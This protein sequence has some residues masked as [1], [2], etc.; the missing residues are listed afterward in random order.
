VG[1]DG[2]ALSVSLRRLAALP[3]RTAAL[4]GHGSPTTIAGEPWLTTRR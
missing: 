2:E 1:G 3:P 4:P